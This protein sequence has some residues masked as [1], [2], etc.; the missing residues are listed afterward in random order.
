MERANSEAAIFLKILAMNLS[1]YREALGPDSKNVESS[2]RERLTRMRISNEAPE[3]HVI[4]LIYFLNQERVRGILQVSVEAASESARK[5]HL[6]IG[7]I[8][9]GL[10]ILSSG[11]QPF[12][13]GRPWPEVETVR[14]TLR[15]PEVSAEKPLYLKEAV[16]ELNRAMDAED[17]RKVTTGFKIGAGIALGVV[18][19]LTGGPVGSVIGAAIGGMLGKRSSTESESEKKEDGPSQAG[20]GPPPR[21]PPPEGPED[22]PEDPKRYLSGWTPGRVKLAADFILTVQVTGKQIS[23]RPGAGSSGFPDFSGPIMINVHGMGMEFPDG[24]MKILDVPAKGDSAPVE[25]AVKA[26]R[27]GVHPINITAW[28]SAAHIAG[29]T[30]QVAVAVLEVEGG[31]SFLPPGD[32]T[33]IEYRQPEDGEYTL[34]VIYEQDNSRYRFQ[35]RGGELGV[36]SPAYSKSLTGPY[37][38]NYQGMLEALNAQARNA[39]LLKP[40]L[41][42]LWLR[43]LGTLLAETLMPPEIKDVLWSIRARICRLNIL[44]EGDNMPWELLY[45]NPPGGGAGVFVAELAGVARWR[46]GPPPPALINVKPAYLVHPP[47]SPAYTIAE[48]NNM[49]DLFPDARIIGEIKELLTLLMEGNFGMLHF[50]SHHQFRAADATGSYIPFGDERFDMVFMGNIAK[51]QYRKS[52]PLIFMNSCA[53]AGTAPM[54]TEM[55]SWA[56]RYLRSG[57]GGFVGSLWDITDKRAPEFAQAFYGELKN[58]ATLDAAM[59]AGRSLIGARDAGDPTRLAYTLYGNPLAKLSIL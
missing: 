17:E 28:N 51:N 1:A 7:E 10:E 41:Q 32:I 30:L 57:A 3:L 31:H 20:D 36:L 46:Y 2:I 29:L 44:S 37:L 47:N 33:T 53:S 12:L 42:Y 6:T 48:T 13:V 23:S 25:F 40:D 15:L 14:K 8:P 39:Y 22:G 11:V 54:Y 21:K 4:D 26:T 24:N 58:G 59:K 34:E 55:S 52:S 35:L 43:G 38:A 27:Q 16:D 49:M 18:G 50:S 56:D 9:P 5:E 19:F 45:L